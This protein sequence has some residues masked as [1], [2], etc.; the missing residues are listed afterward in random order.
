ML[1]IG[2][3]EFGLAVVGVVLCAAL[4]GCRPGGATPLAVVVSGDT[5]GWI[6]PCGCVSNQSGGLA[7]RA[8]YAAG[9]RQEA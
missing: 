4:V 3:F 2:W 8:A 7:R 5:S 6:A 9:L 1:T